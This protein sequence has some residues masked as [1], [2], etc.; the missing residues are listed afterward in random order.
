MM[1]EHGQLLIENK[2]TK[3]FNDVH[4][5]QMP[6]CLKLSGISLGFLCNFNARRFKTGALRV[7]R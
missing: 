4:P 3:E 6:A 1:V 2:A 5:A 7:V